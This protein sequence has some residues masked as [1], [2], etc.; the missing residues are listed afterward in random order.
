MQRRSMKNPDKQGIIRPVRPC[1][2]MYIVWQNWEDVGF[3]RLIN[4]PSLQDAVSE[5]QPNRSGLVLILNKHALNMTFNWLCNTKSIPGVHENAYIVTLDQESSS[6]LK[7]S[8]PELKQINIVVPGL[9]DPFNYG[10][11][12]YQLFYLFRAN[13]ARAIL[14]YDRSFWMI[15]QDTYW[16]DNLLN[17]NTEKEENVDILFDRASDKGPLVAGTKHQVI[18]EYTLFSGGYYHAKPTYNSKSYFA[19]LA[20]DIS[21]WYAPDNAYMT[22][23]C[24]V[25]GLAKCGR[26]SFDLITNWQWLQGTSSGIPPKFIQ[27]DGETKLGGKL[28]K[29][30]KIGFYFLTDGDDQSTC[31]ITSVENTKSILDS[32][33]SQ[34][35]K[36]ASSSHKQFK[37]YQ[38]IVDTFYSTRI[39][40]AVMNHFILPYAHYCMLSM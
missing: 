24:E 12:Y 33:I 26:L 36:V 19:K 40:A 6:A 8:W 20:K 3:E 4:N 14:H 32:K 18:Y 17:I 39:G 22:S 16:N 13:L 2:A 21:W 11:G 23:L 5:M 30:R 15:Q 1:M 37:M 29:M 28:A 35:D 27:F 38:D 34:W 25:S 31:N 10:D 7:K 9:K